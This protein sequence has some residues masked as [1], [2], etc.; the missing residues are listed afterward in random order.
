MMRTNCQFSALYSFKIY[1]YASHQW[2]GVEFWI[3]KNH[4]FIEV[5]RSIFERT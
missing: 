3:M 5:A 1:N 4:I 2:Y